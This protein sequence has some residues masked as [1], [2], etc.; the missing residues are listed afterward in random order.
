MICGCC[1]IKDKTGK[2]E[3]RGHTLTR[4]PASIQDRMDKKKPPIYLCE[5]CDGGA[6]EIALS[7][8]D[9]ASS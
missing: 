3:K 5:Y 9:E 2:V 4:L 1:T 6:L 7:N 8:Q